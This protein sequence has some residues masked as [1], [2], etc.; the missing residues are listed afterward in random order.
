MLSTRIKCADMEMIIS[1]VYRP[2][3]TS[4]RLFLE[5]LL[6]EIRAQPTDVRKVLVGDFNMDQLLKEYEEMVNS[7]A[8]QISMVQKVTYSTHKHGGILDLVIDS[9]PSGSVDWMPTPFSDHFVVYY[10]VH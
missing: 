8:Q 1:V 9:E 2:S 7:F 3:K 10:N 6:A 5:E 4:P